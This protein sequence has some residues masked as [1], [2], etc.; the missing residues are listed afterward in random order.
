MTWSISVPHRSRQDSLVD[1][2]ALVRH[3]P[4]RDEDR[5][6]LRQLVIQAQ[7]DGVA[8]SAGELID[9]LAS[10]TP[11]QRRAMLDAARSEIGLQSTEMVDARARLTTGVTPQ[12]EL[13][14]GR[15]GMWREVTPEP[16]WAIGSSGQP[17]NLDVAEAEAARH[18]TSDE[19][20]RRQQEAEAV[21]RQAE[22]DALRE[23]A[24]ARRA[25]IERELP[26]QMRG[27]R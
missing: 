9:H 1:V 5:S 26:P 20:R 15:D 25:Q 17:V 12:G 23:H 8:S 18:R 22:V 2:A 27:M 21:Q 3:A 19:S 14:L 16:R 13:R 6:A 11:G 10:L 7:I 4:G 24:R